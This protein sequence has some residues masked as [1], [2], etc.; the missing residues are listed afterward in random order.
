MKN[1]DPLSP[2]NTSS[3]NAEEDTGTEGLIEDVNELR[4]QLQEKQQQLEQDGLWRFVD[5]SERYN[6]A[7]LEDTLISQVFVFQ[8]L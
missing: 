8:V 1:S 4:Q 5:A 3:C 7:P 6:S 2:I